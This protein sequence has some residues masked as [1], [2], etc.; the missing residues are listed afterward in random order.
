MSRNNR[1]VWSEGMFLR[2][3]HYQQYTRYWENYIAGRVDSLNGFPWGFLDINLDEKL[4]A[5]GKVAIESASGVFQDGTPF[6]IPADDNP[7]LTVE[8][9]DTIKNSIVYL[10]VPLRRAG[11]SEIAYEEGSESLAR[12]LPSESEV[13]DDSTVGGGTATIQLSS[14]GTRIKLESDHLDDYACLPMGRIVEV[15]TDGSILLDDK[16]IPSVLAARASPLLSGFLNELNGLLDHRAQALAARLTVSDRGGAAEIQDF[17]LLQTVN[18]YLPLVNHYIQLRQLHPEFLF[19]FLIMM[20]G[21]MSTFMRADKR[22]EELPVY[23]HDRLQ[24]CFEPVI[25]QLRQTLSMVIE[26][27]AVS[28]PLQER[29][30]GIRVG[31][32]ADKS[33]LDDAGFVLAVAA[34]VPS[35]DIRQ[36][37]PR[38]ITI[39]ATEQIRQLV[40]VQ[41]PGIRIRAMP[42][43]P[44]QV[45]Y[46]SGF[47]Y[48][49]LERVGELWDQLKSSGGIAIHLSGEY[50]GLKM[51]LW[52][53]R[54]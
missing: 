26:Q 3:Q 46:H 29:K 8:I 17:L 15:R 38:Q 20:V 49:E 19:Q 36:H 32:V 28:I 13:D 18:R 45:P 44:R 1:V 37:L 51:E 42:A 43:A 21:E 47:V 11:G 25:T 23:Q 54:G 34:D 27:N 31:L 5:L 9:P 6:N 14:L 7:P 52:A 33:L 40:N 22:V 35:E 12:Y 53:I 48:F 50:P 30:F 16:F 24:E 39:G 41:M 2:P 10:C 4:L